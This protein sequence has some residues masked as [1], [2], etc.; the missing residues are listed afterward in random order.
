MQVY[1]SHSYRDV[2]I[3]SYFL[4]HFADEDVPL[5]ADQKT[6]IWCVAKLERF[7]IETN[8]FISIIPRRPSEKDPAGY[9]PY[10][11]RELD[12]ARRA[13]VPRL[14]FVDEQVLKRHRLNF[15][16]DA[17]AFLPE[18][19]DRDGLRHREAINTFR[20]AI[21][22]THR[23]IRSFRPNDAT[24]IVGPGAVL[25]SSAEDVAEILRRENYSVTLLSARLQERGLDDIRLLETLWR[26]ELCV[27]MLNS[28]LSNAH[29]A[30]A[31]A[32]SYCIPSIRLQYDSR[33]SDCSPSISGMIRWHES[34]D[35]LV[36][37]ARQVTS[38]KEGLVSPLEIA[39]A[40]STTDA[41]RSIGT[42]KWRARTDNI[43]D[44]RDGA[45]LIEHVYPGHTFIQDEVNR[46]RR[47]LN[48]PL[49][50][51]RSR[52]SSMEICR[53]LYGSLQRL[54]IGYEE[55]PKTGS[56]EIQVIRTPTQIEAHKTATCLDLAC[57][58]ASLLEAAGQN[59]V[60][61]VLDGPGFGHAL[62]GYRTL[63][64]PSWPNP[65]LGDLL[66]AVKLGDA[67]L[68]ESTGAVEADRP[69]GAETEHEREGKLLD[70]MDAKTAAVRMIEKSEIQLRCLADIRSLRTPDS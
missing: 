67:V 66:R 8:G 59:P 44:K 30:L 32:N 65:K 38:Y 9:S 42:M 51:N 26:S 14:L 24:L 63:D 35:M 45:A 62:A 49:G 53:S 15:P 23:P 69:V 2:S 34:G 16:E 27:F 57:L 60:V 20:L 39:Q 13:R 28:G 61:V 5:G 33:S 41:A 70:F 43:W 6:D 12:L 54:R 4:Q 58:F 17:V 47:D 11:G 40:S 55:E 19:P 21:E 56:I 25:R 50:Q 52:E 29:L 36:E 31:I 7:L 18:Q 10:I 1:F 22:S 3:N 48:R 68:F 46:V 64:E 37:L